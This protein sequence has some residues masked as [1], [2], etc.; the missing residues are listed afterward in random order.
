MF[1]DPL[2]FFILIV[3]I[4]TIDCCCDVEHWINWH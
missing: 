4:E 1:F 3:N 2:I